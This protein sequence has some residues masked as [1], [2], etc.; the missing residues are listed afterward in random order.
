MS[1]YVIV[2]MFVFSLNFRDIINFAFLTFLT[3]HKIANFENL[4]LKSRKFRKMRNVNYLNLL[5]LMI[6]L[7]CLVFIFVGETNFSQNS[8]PKSI[9]KV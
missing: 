8:L 3:K 7:Y 9:K 4:S 1:L 2:K 5:F 6:M